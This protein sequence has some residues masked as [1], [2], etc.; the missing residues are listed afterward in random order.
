MMDKN[1]AFNDVFEVL[2]TALILLIIWI[3]V[4]DIESSHPIDCDKC[5]FNRIQNSVAQPPKPE[6][7]HLK[8]QL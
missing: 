6:S 8:G 1:E 2:L 5:C 4:S 7:K 3:Y